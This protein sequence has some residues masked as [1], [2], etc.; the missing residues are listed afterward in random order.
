MAVT[1]S[2]AIE[3]K[4]AAPA[5]VRAWRTRELLWMLGASAF[6][7]GGLYLVYQSRQPMLAATPAPLNLNALNAR[8]DLLPVLAPVIPETAL[9]AF[10]A[11]KIYYATGSLSNV[12]ALARLRIR[13]DELAAR[14]L[15]PLRDR[16]GDRA[17]APLLTADQF[18]QLKPLLAV[19][20]A[21]RFRRAFIP[22]VR[23]V[24]RRV[25]CRAH[26]PQRLRLYRRSI[27]AAR[28]AIALRHR[29]DSDGEPARSAARQSALRRFRPRR[30][31]GMRPPR[32]AG[33][34]RFPPPVWQTSASFR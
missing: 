16:L 9:R 18:R 20:T 22:V 12:G 15:K 8:E 25:P 24:L 1:R 11:Q 13:A 31:H 4:A 26:L 29:A 23:I 7:A 2:R 28:N 14:N 17:S 33:H 34:S 30:G 10:A 6:V 27:T 32:R 21:A 3:R 5:G 19:R